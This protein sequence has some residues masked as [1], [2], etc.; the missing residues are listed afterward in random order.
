M[1]KTA[2]RRDIDA[3][4]DGENQHGHQG[5]A[6]S[7]DEDAHAITQVLEEAIEPGP[8]P[9]FAGLLA[10]AEDIAEVVAAGTGSHFAV[11]FHVGLEFGVDAATINEIENAAPK[12]GHE[13]SPMRCAECPGWLA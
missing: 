9:G 10:H 8:A 3:D 1:L 4:A 2:E 6:G 11:E 13:E 12:L 7:A 5:E